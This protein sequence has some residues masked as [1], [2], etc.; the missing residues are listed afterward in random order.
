LFA[1]C[2]QNDQIKEDETDGAYS[3]YGRRKEHSQDI[4]G[5][6]RTRETTMKIYSGLIWLMTS[7]GLL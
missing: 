6:T 7:G 3:T 2:N 4:C 1:K 5:D